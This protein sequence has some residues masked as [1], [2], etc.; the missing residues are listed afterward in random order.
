MALGG[1]AR[2]QADTPL[3]FWAMGREGE[4]VGELLG[5][6]QREHPKLQVRVEKLPWSAAHE[7]LLTAFA[8]DAMPDIAQLGNTWIA[9][10][11]ALGALE[12]LQPWADAAGIAAADHFDGIW[13]TNQV[14]GAL[15]GV[16][17]YV[18]T[19]LLFYRTDLFA[20]GRHHDDA[21]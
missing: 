13:R 8:G 1:C 9:E 3:R 12:P 17:W 16:P 4:V 2:A 14:D 7:K 11:A 15:Y 19:R 18:D 20:R 5:D 6:F 21:R 10:L